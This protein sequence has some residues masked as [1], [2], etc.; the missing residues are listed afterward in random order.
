[1]QCA[2]GVNACRRLQ[3]DERI[4]ERPDWGTVL[5]GRSIDEVTSAQYYV[6]PWTRSISAPCDSMMK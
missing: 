5:F 1:M 6:C 2:R 4:V 3:L